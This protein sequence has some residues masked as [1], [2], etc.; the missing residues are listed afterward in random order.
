MSDPLYR[1]IVAGMTWDGRRCEACWIPATT[2]GATQCRR[3]PT[4]LIVRFVEL[5]DESD[6]PISPDHDI[7]NDA[8]RWFCSEHATD[9]MELE[10]DCELIALTA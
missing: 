9:W 1:Y 6:E 7:Y 10:P 8:L 5:Y 4:F 3:Y 2:Q